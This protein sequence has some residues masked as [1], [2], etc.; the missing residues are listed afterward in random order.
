[1]RVL[2]DRAIST[3][4]LIAPG[5]VVALMAILSV[6]AISALREQQASFDRFAAVQYRQT[7]IVGTIV[8]DLTR[9][10]TELYHMLSLKA[11]SD[12]QAPVD[13][14][15]AGVQDFVGRA[16]KGIAEL[17]T[18]ELD[19]AQ[20]KALADLKKSVEAYRADAEK[21]VV[22]GAADLGTGVLLMGNVEES[23]RAASAA[24]AHIRDLTDGAGTA[25]LVASRGASDQALATY[26]MLMIGA[27]ALALCVTLTVGRAIARPLKALTRA[28][29]RLA[30]GDTSIAV[31][32]T[33]RR[34]E[35]GAMAQAVGVFRANAIRV[36][37]Q[38]RDKA[39]D[40]ERRAAEDARIRAEAEQ[41][42][43]AEAAALV[44]GSLGLGLKELASGNLAF[45]LEERLPEAYEPLR[46]DLNATVGELQQLVRSITANASGIRTGSEEISQ[47]SDDLSRR[48]EQQAASLEETAA[49]L[50]EI[51]A[52]VRKSAEGARHA[53]DVVAQTREDAERSAEIVKRAVAAMSAIE[54]S[55]G[56]ISSIIGVIDEIAFQTSLLALN[57]GVE[58]ARAGEAGRGFAVVAQEVR[59][60]A[61]RSAEAAKEIKALIS[62]STQQVGA[63][64][65]LVGQTGQALDRMLGQVSD[66]NATVS[67]IAA[68]AQEQALG[69]SQV[70][71]A[72]NQMDKVTQQNAAMVEQSTAA[73][74][75][76][77]REAEQL[78]G[79][80]ARFS[81]GESGDA[82]QP[83]R[84]TARPAAAVRPPA[85]PR[86]AAPASRGNL[87]LVS[88]PEGDWEE[89]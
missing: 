24:A 21:V 26:K 28:M 39:A 73:S 2:N 60:L 6:L 17:A 41:A 89:F 77:A 87:A 42:A 12:E 47:S 8:A 11:A 76:L 48:T 53:R 72:V 62:A 86:A 84:R 19:E 54:T 33:D 27:L 65:E 70:N 57:A 81:T 30:D 66:I 55:S 82:R 38:E 32:D 68:S 35:I 13:R 43:A 1:M 34:D 7:K 83:D 74:H 18:V 58:A 25:S 67:E 5:L 40:Q 56:Q 22:V 14:A 51:T 10:E 49:A 29:L 69:L 15:A 50:D 20:T 37:A 80:V 64:V 71:T 4:V 16:V 52:T 88:A 46:A 75:S 61:Q 45:R 59:G 85:R 78:S 23:Y 3:K 63:G 31:T 44:V 79:L 36:A 9:T